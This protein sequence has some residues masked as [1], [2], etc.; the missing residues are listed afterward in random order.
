MKR[1]ILFTILIS[2]LVVQQSCDF[3]SIACCNSDSPSCI[4]CFVDGGDW[5]PSGTWIQDV[6][7]AT[8]GTEESCVADGGKPYYQMRLGIHTLNF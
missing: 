6:A 3:S 5:N 7:L 2:L 8:L 1:S 4:D